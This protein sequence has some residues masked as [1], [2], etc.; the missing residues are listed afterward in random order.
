MGPS[1]LLPQPFLVTFTHTFTFFV[2]HIFERAILRLKFNAL[3]EDLTSYR[4]T[5][6]NGIIYLG[7][8]FFIELV[9]K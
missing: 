5:F 9:L 2:L 3:F 8:Q 1:K 4:H 6:I 7:H